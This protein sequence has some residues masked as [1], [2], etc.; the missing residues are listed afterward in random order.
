VC[1]ISFVAISKQVNILR[2][3]PKSMLLRASRDNERSGLIV[4][5]CGFV[6]VGS[7]KLCFSVVDDL[8]CCS[9]LL[10]L[11]HMMRYIISALRETVS[12]QPSFT[13]E[14][15]QSCAPPSLRHA[16]VA[17]L[18]SEAIPL[19]KVRHLAG[20]GT[21]GKYTAIRRCIED[22][23]AT[24]RGLPQRGALHVRRRVR[25]RLARGCNRIV[26]A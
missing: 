16:A 19:L 10:S 23:R 5:V 17:M 26:L 3:L 1:V 11:T 12:A 8:Q 6:A 18:S 14:S 9:I 22:I 20:A 24:L 7:T 13:F 21:S 25:W 4:A 2:S 15:L